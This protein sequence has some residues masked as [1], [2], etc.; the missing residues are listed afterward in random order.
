MALGCLRQRVK[1]HQLIRLVI[2]ARLVLTPLGRWKCDARGF[3]P[4]G[5]LTVLG[6]LS[7]GVVRVP[8]LDGK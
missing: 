6:S 7:A 2:L 4:I 1:S 5:F 8:V 3:R